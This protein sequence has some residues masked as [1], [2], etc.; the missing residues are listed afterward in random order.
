MSDEQ[1]REVF[2]RWFYREDP[3]VPVEI[4]GEHQEA[5][6]YSPAR[7]GRPPN[8]E[9]LPE[10]TKDLSSVLSVEARVIGREGVE[11]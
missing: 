10:A 1:L 9:D 11:G 7:A 3:M 6:V 8:P 5:L 4:G 2:H